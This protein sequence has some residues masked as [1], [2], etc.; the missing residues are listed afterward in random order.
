MN[1]KTADAAAVEFALAVLL[2]Q[3]PSGRRLMIIAQISEASAAAAAT[4]LLPH[5]KR[6]H[7]LLALALSRAFTEQNGSR[8]R[9]HRDPVPATVT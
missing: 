3:I 2:R 4:S 8:S 5:A 6:A 9:A 7:A 1:K